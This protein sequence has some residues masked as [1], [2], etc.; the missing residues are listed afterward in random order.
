LRLYRS[1]ICAIESKPDIVTIDDLRLVNP[2]PELLNYAQSIDLNQLDSKEHGHVPYVIILIQLLQTW[3]AEHGGSLPKT[4][5][6]KDEFRE[7]IKS[8]SRDFFSEANFEEALN[9]VRLCFKGE[10]DDIRDS[11]REVLED[12]K[13]DDSN[14]KNVFWQLASALKRFIEKEGTLPVSG[15][16]PDMTSTTDFYITLQNIYQEKAKKD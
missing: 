9:Q 13:T 4:I 5:T 11:L 8:A 3:R 16:V 12:S 10:M 7:R 2:F 1:E 15:K 14:E 6:E